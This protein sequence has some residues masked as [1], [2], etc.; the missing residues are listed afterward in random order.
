MM[1]A[2]VRFA[3]SEDGPTGTEYAVLLGVIVLVAVTAI[4]GIGTTV[5]ATFASLDQ[6]LAVGS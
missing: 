5:G 1:A 4:S 3:R 6:G 2:F